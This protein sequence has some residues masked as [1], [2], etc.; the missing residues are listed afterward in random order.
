MMI[1]NRTKS[2]DKR[3]LI[4]KAAVRLFVEHGFTQITM[5]KVAE[6]AGVSKQT[7]YS[8]FGNKEDLFA[9]AIENKCLSLGLADSL[10]LEGELKTCLTLFAL[11]FGS[12]IIE[13]E[14]LKTHKL[15]AFEANHLPQLAE[16]FFRLGPDVVISELSRYFAYKTEQ[17]KLNTPEPRWAASQFLGMVMG[18]ARLRAELNQM[19][20]KTL[21]EREQYLLNSVDMFLKAYQA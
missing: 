20:E 13:D 2:E 10:H 21:V 17:G 12:F 1:K 19:D 9:A 5:A 8:H 16:I 14:T 3:R 11:R 18:E 15:C 6:H 7:V 4:L